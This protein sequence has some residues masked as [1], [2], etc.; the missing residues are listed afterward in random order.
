MSHL[1]HRQ[2]LP[3][4]HTITAEPPAGFS[5]VHVDGYM[6]ATPDDEFGHGTGGYHSELVLAL[7]PESVWTGTAVCRAT[8]QWF[9]F[10]PALPEGALVWYD[11][12]WG[13]GPQAK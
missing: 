6:E 8:Q 5:V 9:S 1:E 2:L 13:N 7:P 11:H 4:T 12:A 10:E 3:M